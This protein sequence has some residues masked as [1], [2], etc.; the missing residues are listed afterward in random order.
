MIFRLA[1]HHSTGYS[2]PAGDLQRRRPAGFLP[3]DTRVR[4][5]PAHRPDRPAGGESG[6]GHGKIGQEHLHNELLP[7]AQDDA[8]W[9]AQIHD[10]KDTAL[11][12]TDHLPDLAR[13]L[14]G[15]LIMNC[16]NGESWA[17]SRPQV[18]TCCFQVH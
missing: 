13:F 9:L 8:H 15:N 11:K 14:D 16:L 10:T 5:H 6:P 18:L 7:L 1:R 2:A 17:T 3:S 12:T 4:R